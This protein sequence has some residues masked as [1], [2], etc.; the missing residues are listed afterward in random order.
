MENLYYIIGIVAG[1]VAIAG[2]IVGVKRS[3]NKSVSQNATIKGNN[4]KVNQT[5]TDKDSAE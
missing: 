5:I 4:N 1:I 2:T 3:K